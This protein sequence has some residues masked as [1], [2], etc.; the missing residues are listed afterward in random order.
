MSVWRCTKAVHKTKPL[1]EY[2]KKVPDSR[3]PRKKKHNQAEVLTYMVFAYMVGRYTIRRA[4]RWA[5]NN[6]AFLRKYMKLSGGIASVSTVSRMLS[7]IDE[8][9][10]GL[11][12]MEWISEIVKT[13]GTHIIIDGK[14]LRASTDKRKEG[15]SIPYIL[16]VL[17]VATELV[18]GQ[19]PI[20]EKK[21]EITY[22]PKVLEMLDITDDIITID[23]IGTQVKIMDYILNNGGHFMFTVKKNNKSVYEEIIGYFTQI[24]STIE[25]LKDNPDRKEELKKVKAEIDEE[26]TSERNRERDEYRRLVTQSCDKSFFTRQSEIFMRINTMGC[27]TQ[28]RIP[29]ERNCY[30]DDVT[31]NLKEFLEKGSIKKPKIT[32]GDDIKDDIQK[33]GL[34]SDL[35]MN[36]KT[37]LDIHRQ[38]WK[39]ENSLHHVLDDVFR[40]DRSPAKGSKNNLAQIRKFAYNILKII[41]IHEDLDLG[42]MEMM[43]YSADNLKISAKYIF[44]GI[45][46]LY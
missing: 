29:I 19:L 3:S 26:K 40:E 13:T 16:N 7:E 11:A 30:G 4:I 45:D 38:H 44:G 23:A 24:D 31:R 12:F 27:L 17:D 46:S 20:D 36:S 5:E 34:I 18:I 14:A 10:F 37:M 1:L 15:S 21:N 43:D 2:M 28:V 32:E 25:L 33:V 8:I 22:I 35:E 39:I 6:I 41:N 42:V 9:D